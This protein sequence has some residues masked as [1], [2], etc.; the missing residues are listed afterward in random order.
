MD[1]PPDDTAQL[2]IYVLPSFSAPPSPAPFVTISHARTTTCSEDEINEKKRL[3]KKRAHKERHRTNSKLNITGSSRPP[4]LNDVPFLTHL[5]AIGP[6]QPSFATHS[7]STS[8]STKSE[9]RSVLH[10]VSFGKILQSTNDK[11]IVNGSVK[12]IGR[13]CIAF[14]FLDSIAINIFMLPQ[15]VFLCYNALSVELYTYPTIQCYSC[16]RYGHTK[17]QCRH[18]PRC[19]KC[20]NA[21]IGESCTVRECR[22]EVSYL[23]CLSRYT[24]TSKL[25]P[26]LDG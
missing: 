24:A 19:F 21:H 10:P 7:D 14:S 15:R 1:D 22:D 20:G 12:R 17:A 6:T 16:C 18:Q 2:P 5:S 26:K 13:N 25:C 4:S 23:H 9:G 3:S 8:P 11:D